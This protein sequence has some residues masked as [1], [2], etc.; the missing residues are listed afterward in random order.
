MIVNSSEKGW[1]IIY[2]SAHAL[3]AGQIA[4]YL[5]DFWDREYA[6]ETLSAIIE[7]DNYKEP[8][9]GEQY[10]TEAGAPKDFALFA[11]DGATRYRESKRR[12]ERA[13]MKSRWI[14]LLQGLHIEHLYVKEK[15][16]PELSD[17]IE[18][19]KASRNETLLALDA[20]LD[21]L[22]RAYDILAFSDRLSLILCRDE[23]PAMQRELEVFTFKDGTTVYIKRD[24]S[25]EITP[26][27]F[28]HQNTVFSAETRELTR[29]EFKNDLQLKEELSQARVIFKRWKCSPGAD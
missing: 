23:I 10:L 6:L 27:I 28:S 3:L 12:L 4:V 1:E 21:D 5:N 11:L 25:I 2:Q 19:E 26:W 13:Y 20:T 18:S 9:S 24:K 29:L 22:F 14:G 8:F 17:L 16:S 7:H 15:T